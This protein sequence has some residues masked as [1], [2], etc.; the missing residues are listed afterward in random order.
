MYC[1][2][3]FLV[4]LRVLFSILTHYLV[5]YHVECMVVVYIEVN[6]MMLPSD[7]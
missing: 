7:F 2:C 5:S 6:D 1:V 3:V 4:V